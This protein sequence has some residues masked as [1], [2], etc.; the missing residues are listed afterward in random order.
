MAR[1]SALVVLAALL[2]MAARADELESAKA[3]M[4]LKDFEAAAAL[5]G[6]LKLAGPADGTW[7]F[8]IGT[9]GTG[10]LTG[11]NF[12]VV[13]AGGGQAC[14][15]TWWVAEAVTMTTS[16]FKGNILAGA[17]ITLTGGTFHGNAWA[18]ASGV[19][20]VTIKG[21]ATSGCEGSNG[22]GNGDGKGKCNQGVGN[23]DE[24]GCDPGN[25]NNTRLTN[26]ESG[27]TPGNPGRKGKP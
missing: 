1:R 22:G 4:R 23:G 6:T 26:D 24:E 15:V 11:T 8:K 16:D 20:D 18:G 27:G 7:I 25:S 10:A 2:A 21:T 12:S 14:N 5:T 13:M 17:A 3:A 9:G 19:G